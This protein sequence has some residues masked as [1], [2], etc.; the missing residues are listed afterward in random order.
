MGNVMIHNTHGK[1]NVERASLAFVTA[2]TALTAGQ[3]VTLL[4]TINGVS[5]ATKGYA[6]ELQANGFA[7]LPELIR[8][9]TENDGQIW[10]CGACAKPRNIAEPDLVPGAKIVGAATAIEAMVNGAHTLSF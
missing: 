4:L 3:Q 6:T 9:F 7:P 2:N 10:V 1:E 8:Q 5:V